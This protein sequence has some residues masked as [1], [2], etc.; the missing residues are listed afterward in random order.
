MP[1]ARQQFNES[2]AA[3]YRF[4]PTDEQVTGLWDTVEGAK[5]TVGVVPGMIQDEAAVL[6]R[7]TFVLDIPR[8]E[9][10]AMYEGQPITWFIPIGDITLDESRE[11]YDLLTSE[12]GIEL[13]ER[14]L[15]LRAELLVEA[16][17][18]R[19][20]GRSC[21]ALQVGHRGD[22]SDEQGPRGEGPLQPHARFDEG[23][24]R[25]ADCT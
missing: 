18:F 11:H 20:I 7:L 8:D 12:P 19:G 22:P 9:I 16:G 21:G 3:K 5:V 4:D 23:R 24:H 2:L 1:L 13:R 17:G 25:P 14:P 6:A 15:R 10:Q